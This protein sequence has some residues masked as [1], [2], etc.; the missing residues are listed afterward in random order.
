M[1]CFVGRDRPRV[2]SREQ[3]RRRHCWMCCGRCRHLDSLH[4]ESCLVHFGLRQGYLLSGQP[5]ARPVS[6]A[7]PDPGPD[8]LRPATVHRPAW[9]APGR[10]RTAASR[11]RANN[12]NNLYYPVKHPESRPVMSVGLP[13]VGLSWQRGSLPQTIFNFLCSS[14]SCLFHFPLCK[15]RF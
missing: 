12:A 7:N 8:H 2:L 1:G 5:G 11:L 14:L 4:H 15:I 3:L 6:E 10:L 9:T 13:V